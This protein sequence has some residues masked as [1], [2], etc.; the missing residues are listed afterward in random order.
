MIKIVNQLVFFRQNFG[1]LENKT[2]ICIN[3]IRYD[4]QNL[5]YDV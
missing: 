2:Y 4:A 5:F 1:N 3:K